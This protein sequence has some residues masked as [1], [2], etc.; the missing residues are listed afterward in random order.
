VKSKHSIIVGAFLIGGVILFGV[1]LFMIG[2]QSN[3]FTHTF[4]VYAWFPKMSGL[5]TSAQV[6]ISGYNAGTVSSIDIPQQPDGKFRV[7]LKIDEKFKP[8]IRESSVAVIQSQG[9]VGDQFV[10]IDPGDPKSA[11]CNNKCTIQSKEATNMSDL[12]EEG[13]GVM[14]AMESTLHRAGDVAQNANQAL[15]T[16]NARGKAGESGAESMKQTVLDAQ[17]AA[18]NVAED[19]DALKHNFFLRGFFKRRGYY[20]LADMTADQYRK[21]DFVK[22]KKSMRVWLP[23]DELFT[24]SHGRD[25]LTSGGRHQLDKAMSQLV[26]Y[27][28]NKPMMIEGYSS[29]GAPSEE[30]EKSDER[31][32]LVRQYLM[33]HFQLQPQKTGSMPLS[34]SPPEKTGKESWDG[35]SL[36]VLT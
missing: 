24:N 2:S 28:P 17:R 13:K 33:E 5:T 4:K 7:T 29:H 20:D 23:A 15:S 11:A 32:T 16:F 36:V 19:A 26:Q 12:M 8:L 22:E 27:L 30:Y 10:E 3:L 14:E 1:G 9:M 21:S 25:E 34:D 35:I 31:A 6:H 18:N